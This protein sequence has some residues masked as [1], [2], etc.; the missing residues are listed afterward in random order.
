[1]RILLL[2]VLVGL[3]GCASASRE[4]DNAQ[5]APMAQLDSTATSSAAGAGVDHEFKPPAGYKT[6]IVDWSVLYCKKTTV[7]GSRFPK[8]VC[9]TEAQLKDHMA[10]NDSMG[11]DKDQASR[12]CANPEACGNE[13]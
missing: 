3:A 10:T 13:F 2:A 4:A 7:L 5:V 8:E 12:I 1:M 9:M 6:K 11:R